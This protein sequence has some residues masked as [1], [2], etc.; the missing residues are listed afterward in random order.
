MNENDNRCPKCDGNHIA[1]GKECKKKEDRRNLSKIN[2][3]TK[4]SY[5]NIRRS[6]SYQTNETSKIQNTSNAI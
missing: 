4:K 6:F 1:G 2:S 3:R 5:S